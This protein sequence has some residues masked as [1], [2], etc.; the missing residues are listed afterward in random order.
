MM[1]SEPERVSLSIFGRHTV[2]D[3]IEKYDKNHRL[4]YVTNDDMRNI[5][6]KEGMFPGRRN[7]DDLVSL[8]E[9]V[10]ENNEADGIRLYQ[11]PG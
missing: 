1:F 8:L 10:E 5:R 2:H 11:Q 4:F 7:E 6:S 9:R 3:S